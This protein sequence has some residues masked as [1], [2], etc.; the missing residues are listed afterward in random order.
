MEEGR[1]LAGSQARR[2]SS[3]SPLPGG[4]R[5]RGR[6]RLEV[7]VAELRESYAAWQAATQRLVDIGHMATQRRHWISCRKAFQVPFT[8]GP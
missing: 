2:R 8:I 5:Q 3:V 1:R 7:S 4:A 6:Q